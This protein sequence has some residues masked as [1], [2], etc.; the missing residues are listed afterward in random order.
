VF[1]TCSLL[2]FIIVMASNYLFP[3]YVSQTLH[4][5]ALWF[6]GGEITFAV[7]AILA[8]ALLP[9][10]IGRHSAATTIPGTMLVFFGGLVL[11]TVAPFPIVYITA[12]VLVGFGNAGCRVAR[13]ALMLHL[14]PNEVMG[15]VGGFYNVLDRVLRTLLVLAMGVI[16]FSGPPAGF[17]VLLAVLVIAF[18]GVILSREV[19]RDSSPAPV[20]A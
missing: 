6:A 8:G 16:E 13:S 17:A 15:R 7:G 12:N 10:L 4:A 20:P 14:I 5:G 9:R 2:P 3:I 11:I 1:L 19:L 18:V